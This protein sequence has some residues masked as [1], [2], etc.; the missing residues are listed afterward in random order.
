M[1]VLRHKLTWKVDNWIA[2]FAHQAIHAGRFYAD[3]GTSRRTVQTRFSKMIEQ[4]A[5][6]AAAKPR[7]REAQTLP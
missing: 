1:F 5:R 4:Q 6:L 2:G 3:F 7:L